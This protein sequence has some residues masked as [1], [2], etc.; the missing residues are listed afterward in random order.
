MFHKFISVEVGPAPFEEKCAQVGDP[1]YKVRSRRESAAY[2][3][4]LLRVFGSHA[5]AVLSFIRRGFAHDLGRY[6]EVVAYMNREGEQIFSEDRLP[7]MWDHIARAELMWCEIADSYRRRYC[8]G[9]LD[10][11]AIP[12]FFRGPVPAF[13]DHPVAWWMAV[14]LAAFPT[15]GRLIFR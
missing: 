11:M 15:R 2:I 10:L 13:P 6:H 4:Q 3:R 14:G 1:D 9:E 7:P 12:S 5:P 8:A